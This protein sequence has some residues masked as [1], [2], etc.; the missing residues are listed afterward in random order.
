MPLANKKHKSVILT[1]FRVGVQNLVNDQ[2]GP[3]SHSIPAVYPH[4]GGA[5]LT[6]ARAAMVREHLPA[7]SVVA[8]N[9]RLGS[10]H[11]SKKTKHAANHLWAKTFLLEFFKRSPLVRQQMSEASQLEG[12]VSA[13]NLNVADVAIQRNWSS[14][15]QNGVAALDT[16]YLE[17]AMN[18]AKSRTVLDAMEQL[19][20][21]QVCA[22]AAARGPACARVV[23]L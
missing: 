13:G 14:A 3:F 15:L 16:A 2:T 7:A 11:A 4:T 12:N 9:E 10:G 22:L 19:S 23:T 17:L 21:E 20:A 18:R 1:G 5:G 8:F 6:D